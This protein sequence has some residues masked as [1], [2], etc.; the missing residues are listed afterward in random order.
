VEEF[1][2]VFVLASQPAS[3]LSPGSPT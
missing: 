1:D 2:D 3:S